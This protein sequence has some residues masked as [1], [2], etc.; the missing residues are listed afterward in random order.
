MRH[1]TRRWCVRVVKHVGWIW[2]LAALCRS[3][4]ASSCEPHHW[5][6]PLAF[7]CI[8]TGTIYPI[9]SQ[10]ALFFSSPVLITHYYQPFPPSLC[11]LYC[12]VNGFHFPFLSYFSHSVYCL[13]FHQDLIFFSISVNFSLSEGLT[14]SLAWTDLH[15]LP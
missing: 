2:Q 1:S 4:K 13:S 6:F 14:V 11:S 3:I 12:F 10:P 9:S 7:I 5:E 15:W 8:L